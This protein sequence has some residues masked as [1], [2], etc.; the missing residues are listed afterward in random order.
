MR[1]ATYGLHIVLAAC[2]LSAVIIA[3]SAALGG[4]WWSLIGLLPA[5]FTVYFFRDPNRKPPEGD[6]LVLAPADGKVTVVERVDDPE[7]VGEAAWRVGIFLS[8]FNVHLN[9]APLKGRVEVCEHRPGRFLNAIRERAAFENEKNLVGMSCP[10][11]GRVLV[12]QIAGVIARR[13]VCAVKPGREIERGERIGMIMFGSRTDLYIPC[14]TS[15]ITIKPG[16]RVKAGHSV[17]GEIIS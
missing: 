9:R 1:L 2:A 17:V 10:S 12:E 3:G 5:L 7:Y 13:I 4:G 16:D 15:R 6:T 8:I 14:R 11:A